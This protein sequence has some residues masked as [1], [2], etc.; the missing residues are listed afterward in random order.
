MN[1]LRYPWNYVQLAYLMRRPTECL[2]IKS[3]LVLPEYWDTGV[4][5]L[6]FDEM[7]KR[8]V[9]RG[10]TWVDM[11]ITSADN[12]QT[13]VLGTRLGATLYKRWRVYR[14]PV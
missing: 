9:P 7:I 4:L 11:S 1:G 8:A 14:R 13:P 10:Y 2:A 12:P 5:A 6:L 3:L